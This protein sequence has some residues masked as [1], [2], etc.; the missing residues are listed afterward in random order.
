MPLPL[1]VRPSLVTKSAWLVDADGKQVALI[2]YKENQFLTASQ[3]ATAVNMHNELIDLIKDIL[4]T[5]ALPE[6]V[7]RI[8]V[9]LHEDEKQ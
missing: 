7:T 4:F 3:I 9:L 2:E 5:N 8:Q 6:L 1:H